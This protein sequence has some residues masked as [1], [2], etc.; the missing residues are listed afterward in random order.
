M[1]AKK[2]TIFVRAPIYWAKILG[3]PRPNYDGDAKEWTF[4][5]E[6]TDE[7]RD[8]LKTHRLLDRIKDKNAVG[9]RGEYIVLK[10]KELTNTGEKNSPIRIYDSEDQPWDET[11]LLGNGTVA[12]VKI[13]IADYGVGKKKGIYPEAV[14]VQELVEYKSSEFGGMDGGEKSPASSPAK[15]AK[16]DT[17]KEDFGLVDELDDPLP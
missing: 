15:K 2:T 17:F 11:K 8:H 12:D 1:A 3:A 6:V 7:L 9:G 10:K 14:R 4:E 13:T 16:K 5:V